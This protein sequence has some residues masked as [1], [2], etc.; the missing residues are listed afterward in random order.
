MD[1]KKMNRKTKRWEG[2]KDEDRNIKQK[3]IK[4]NRWVK[5][6]LGDADSYKKLNALKA[7]DGS[8][9]EKWERDEIQNMEHLK[10]NDQKTKQI[11]MGKR[12]RWVKEE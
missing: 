4:K 3:K 8:G 9:A 10:I 1:E 12:A 5:N 7:K 6:P 11:Y 2:K